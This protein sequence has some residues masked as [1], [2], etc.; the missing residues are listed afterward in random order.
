LIGYINHNQQ[1]MHMFCSS[2]GSEKKLLTDIGDKALKKA[3][4]SPVEDGENENFFPYQWNLKSG[5]SKSRLILLKKNQ[6]FSDN[7]ITLIN[8]SMLILAEPPRRAIAYE[9]VFEQARK[10]TLTG[11]PNRFVF[12]E[13]IDS[14]MEQA[15][16]HNHPLTLAAL[17]LDHFKKVNDTMSHSMGDEVLKKSGS[18]PPGRSSCN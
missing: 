5:D 15:R 2:H 1:R 3:D 18:H 10:D 8:E 14:I 17:D 9:G 4:N 7:D 11:L 12:E 16:Q 13:R 6:L